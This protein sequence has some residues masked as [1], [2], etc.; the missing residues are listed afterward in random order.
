ML[1]SRLPS[2][3]TDTTDGVSIGLAQSLVRA[4]CYGL[5]SILMIGVAWMIF[6]RRHQGFHDKLARTLVVYDGAAFPVLDTLRTTA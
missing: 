1:A 5:S 3:S 4:V 2:S 6:D